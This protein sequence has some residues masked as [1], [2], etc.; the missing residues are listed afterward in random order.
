FDTPPVGSGAVGPRQGFDH[1]HDAPGAALVG[2]RALSLVFECQLIIHRDHI[3]VVTMRVTYLVVHH[4]ADDG[5]QLMSAEDATM[6]ALMHLFGVQLAHARFSCLCFSLS[7]Q[8]L[9]TACR[10][11]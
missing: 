7:C 10:L 5:F 9:V 11:L 4:V 1:I 3:I 2:G 6:P 8:A